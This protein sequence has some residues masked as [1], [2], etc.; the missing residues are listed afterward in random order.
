MRLAE[1]TRKQAEFARRRYLAQVRPG[2]PSRP[3][4]ARG[5]M[6]LKVH[7]IRVPEEIPRLR[8]GAGGP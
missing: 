2:G 8:E 7:L 5:N 3:L 4:G 1:K 6:N